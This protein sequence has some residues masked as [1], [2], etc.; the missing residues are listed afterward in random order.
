MP[1]RPPPHLIVV[2][3]LTHPAPFRVQVAIVGRLVSPTPSSSRP[4]ATVPLSLAPISAWDPAQVVPIPGGLLFPAFSTD[5]TVVGAAFRGLFLMDDAA[6]S[7]MRTWPAQSVLGAH[8]TP[9]ELAPFGAEGAVALTYRDAFGSTALELL[10]PSAA[11]GGFCGLSL[12]APYSMFAQVFSAFG[13]L[14]FTAVD[15]N[16]ARRLM[17]LD[18]TWDEACTVGATLTPVVLGGSLIVDSR[19]IV[20][21]DGDIFVFGRLD[22]SAPVRLHRINSAGAV[23]TAF[24]ITAT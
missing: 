2:S 12:D 10:K 22:A 7:N 9:L 6:G 24:D 14:H 5:T 11:N 16:G 20:C 8:V 15:A 18:A 17:R 1:V 19:P 4:L 23:A 21:T 3:L 13:K